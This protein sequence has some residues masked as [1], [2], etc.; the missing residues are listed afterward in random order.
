[1]K[2]ILPM[3]LLALMVSGCNQHADSALDAQQLADQRFI[4]QSVDGVAARSNQGQQPEIAFSHDLRLSGMMCNRFFGQG[5]LSHNLLTVKQLG[6]TRMVCSDE[7]LSR[8]D[9]AV[10]E[11]LSN[12][13]QVTLEQGNLTL[14]GGGHTLKYK[15]AQ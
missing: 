5:E 9:R 3:A 13:A 8:W 7:Q 12:G 2:K 4:L 15:T 11:A 10:A 14:K 1:M 6:S